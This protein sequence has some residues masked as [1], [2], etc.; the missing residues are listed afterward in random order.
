MNNIR[1]GAIATILAL[2]VALPIASCG[3]ESGMQ[4]TMT[5][6]Q[7]EERVEHYFRQTLSVLPA[8]ARPE[9]GLIHTVDCDDPTDNGPKGR[10]I[11]SAD[12]QI[13][14]LPAAEYPKYV[15]DLERWWR[16]HNFRILDDERPTYQSISV[17]NNDDGF[18]IRIQDNDLGELYITAT[19]PCV[20]PNGTP[21]P[22]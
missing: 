12:Y 16:D 8:Q 13:H 18:R 20:W 2:L 15:A 10:K 19:S 22:E 17:E 1:S 11:A 3:T 5:V 7:A 21:E 4:R 6:E 14:D 9:A